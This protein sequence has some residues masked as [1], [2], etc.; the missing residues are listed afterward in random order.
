[1]LALTKTLLI[2]SF[3][4]YIWITLTFLITSSCFF[5]YV[6]A[7]SCLIYI[8]DLGPAILLELII[9]VHSFHGK[10]LVNSYNTFSKKNYMKNKWN[11]NVRWKDMLYMDVLSYTLHERGSL[12]C[13]TLNKYRCTM[14]VV[15]EIYFSS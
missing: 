10:Q 6:G 8:L 7:H 1:M 13:T 15:L 12:W 11:Q 2:L 14:Q 9:V 4:L 5:S 3:V